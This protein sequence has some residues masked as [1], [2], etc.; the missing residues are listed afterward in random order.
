MFLAERTRLGRLRRALTWAFYEIG[1]G[2][3]CSSLASILWCLQEQIVLPFYSFSLCLVFLGWSPNIHVYGRI[4]YGL[5]WA[6]K[7][8]RDKLSQFSR[9]GTYL[10]LVARVT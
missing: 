5:V 8:K 9:S 3:T 4:W 6:A 7:R 2:F 1:G 10:G